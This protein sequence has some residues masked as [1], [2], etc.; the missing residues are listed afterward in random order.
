MIPAYPLPQQPDG[1]EFETD[2]ASAHHQQALGHLLALQG[3]GGVEQPRRPAREEGY[4]G[5]HRADRL[6]QHL[7]N[8]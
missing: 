4:G 3:A 2:V 6:G 8:V 5:R 1:A 7:A